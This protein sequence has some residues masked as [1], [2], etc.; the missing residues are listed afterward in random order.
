MHK[1]ESSE[2]S[3][4]RNVEGSKSKTDHYY[5]QTLTE[6]IFL[7]RKCLSEHGVPG[8]DDPIIRSFDIRYD[9]SNYA[10][11]MNGIQSKPD[12]TVIPGHSPHSEQNRSQ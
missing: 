12:N 9:A 5:V 1:Q 3:S 6:H 7:V 4:L 11:S 8:P 10:N 2:P